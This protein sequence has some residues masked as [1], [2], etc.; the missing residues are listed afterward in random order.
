MN[1]LTKPQYRTKLRLL[2]KWAAFF[3]ILFLVGILCIPL[4]LKGR[5][6]VVTIRPYVYVFNSRLN[7][8][9]ILESCANIFLFMPLGI[10]LYFF[11]C[12]PQRKPLSIIMV[13]TVIGLLFSLLIE[14]YQFFL[15]SRL[16][17]VTDIVNNSIGTLLGSIFAF[18]LKRNYRLM[19]LFHSK[20]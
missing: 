17:E 7:A 10:I 5:L 9:P 12:R 8:V 14:T 20:E 19:T 1:T 13:S 3:Y 18:R 15:I 4:P 16:S 11:L 2:A 6:H